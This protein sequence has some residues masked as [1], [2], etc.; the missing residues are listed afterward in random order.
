[1]NSCFT[2]VKISTFGRVQAKNRLFFT[3]KLSRRTNF[4]RHQL[5]QSYL[6]ILAKVLLQT[7]QSFVHFPKDCKVNLLNTAMNNSEFVWKHP[8]FEKN[9]ENTSKVFRNDCKNV[10][11]WSH[12]YLPRLWMTGKGCWAFPILKL[13]RFDNYAISFPEWKILE[14]YAIPKKPQDRIKMTID[15]KSVFFLHWLVNWKNVNVLLD[16]Q[17]T[18]TTNKFAFNYTPYIVKK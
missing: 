2:W 6:Q 5:L 4:L 15:N 18:H 1:M 11:F 14:M 13:Q 10:F 7:K 17:K 16:H 12:T 8:I 9:P 3:F